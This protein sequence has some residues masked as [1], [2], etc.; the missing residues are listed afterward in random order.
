MR[1]FISLLILISFGA[2][3][4]FSDTGWIQTT[5]TPQISISSINLS[6]DGCGFYSIYDYIYY[7][8]TFSKSW[9]CMAQLPFSL[10]QACAV[11]NK[12]KIYIIGGQHYG[13]LLKFVFSYDMET[14]LIEQK[15]PLPIGLI[16]HSCI[17]FVDKIYVFG[18][19][20]EGYGY[21]S[22]LYLYDI[23]LDKWHKL[24]LNY[25]P[26]SGQAS[27]Y[28]PKDGL[29]YFS[30]GAAD[31]F[32]FLKFDPLFLK[33]ENTL[34]GLPNPHSYHGMVSIDKD[35]FIFG[36]YIGN[37]NISVILDAYNIESNSFIQG[38]EMLFPMYLFGYAY[39]NSDLNPQ[40]GAIFAFGGIDENNNYHIMQELLYDLKPPC[41]SKSSEGT[42]ELNKVSYSCNDSIEIKVEDLDLV[43]AGNLNISVWSTTEQTPETINL[44]E[45]PANTGIF[46]GSINTK[47]GSPTTGDG[48]LSINHNDII[49]ARYIDQDDGKGGQNIE[50]EAVANSDCLG[51]L[52][53]NIEVINKE[54]GSIFITWKTD[55][56]SEGTLFYK[57]GNNISSIELPSFSKNKIAKID[58]LLD[59][60]NYSYYIKAKDMNGNETL[61]NN[62][63]KL[64]FFSTGV[65]AKHEYISQDVP[66]NIWDMQTTYSTIIVDR[67]EKIKK[68]MVKIGNLKH[69]W[70]S[71]LQI[72][73]ISPE[74]QRVLLTAC[75][76]GALSDLINTL[77]DDNASLSI[78]EGF[79]PYDGAYRPQD[80]LEVY[81]GKS[82]Q[83]IW[84]L[85]ISDLSY[86]DVGVLYDWSIIFVTEEKKC[87]PFIKYLDY[88]ISDIC[89]GNGSGGAD[90][91]VDAGEEV[92]LIVKIKNLWKNKSTGIWA[93]ISTETQGV[94]ITD[95]NAT[96]P[97][98]EPL[99]EAQSNPDHF[100]FYVNED[101]P[102]G[103]YIDFRINIFSNENP[104]GFQYN[105]SIPVGEISILEENVFYIDF[106]SGIPDDWQVINGG[107][108]GNLNTWNTLNLCQ[109]AIPFPVSQ[110]FAI[111]DS[112]CE[113][114]DSFQDEE[115]VSPQIQLQD[116]IGGYIEFD[117]Y[118][119]SWEDEIADIDIKS[120]STNGS[121]YNLKRYQA[122]NSR[123]PEKVKIDISNFIRNSQ[124]F[125]LR[126]HY[127]NSLYDGWWAIDNL[128]LNY[129]KIGSL[130]QNQ[131]LNGRCFEDLGDPNEN[132]DISSMDA[133]LV[134]QY[135]VGNAE[136]TQIQKCKADVSY[137]FD[138]TSMDASYILMCVVGRCSNLPSRFVPSCQSHGKCQ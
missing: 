50:K 8:N 113:G 114:K 106:S 75:N 100:A 63:G 21:N 125:Q 137:L 15:S 37:S 16:N 127:Y 53:D 99:E 27:I 33:W 88:S 59:C 87:N 39:A 73:I 60:T 120:Q 104:S 86:G 3:L 116:A 101:F 55:E 130:N 109:R 62:N 13:N 134:L 92:A 48:Y 35:I 105:F 17:A 56:F 54:D 7:Y 9:T 72:S 20:R 24:G 122:M 111:V 36:G 22:N 69:S 46:K 28:N 132:G 115:L 2:G 112:D 138:V 64:Y 32:S 58:N 52:I 12:D 79:P 102:C 119:S 10:S 18:G 42:I 121:W 98:L 4:L 133:S 23:N 128:S 118:F 5:S 44:I 123:F 85:E 103:T 66:K 136:L 117:N 51:P 74:G 43:G 29:F 70:V 41:F 129:Y 81:A 78:V 30:G 71:D 68:M 67:N 77:F 11:I 135:V 6:K 34:P 131:C 124:N 38:P 19:L 40:E 93:T 45:T 110:P 97:D 96:F 80:P 61:D 47:D 49:I 57:L 82:T 84:T 89:R 107:N 76:G 25:F 26:S 95:N 31:R 91:F 65:N 83:G 126:F 14:N 94:T 108:T 1:I 90:G